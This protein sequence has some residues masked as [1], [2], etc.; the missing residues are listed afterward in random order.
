MRAVEYMSEYSA[1]DCDIDNYNLG[2]D[3]V[4]SFAS[5][6]NKKLSSSPDAVIR[7]LINFLHMVTQYEIFKEAASSWDSITAEKISNV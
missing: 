7:M 6:M 2:V 3:L 1:S 5:F 4:R